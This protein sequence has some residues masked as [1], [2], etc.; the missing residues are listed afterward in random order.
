MSHAVPESAPRTETVAKPRG[1]VLVIFAFLL[2]ILLGMAAFVV[3]LAW[4]WSNQLQVQRAADAGALAGVIH[5][6]GNPNGGIAA[7]RAES[8]KNGFEHNVNGV[9][10]TANPDPAFPR[11]MIVNVSAPVDTFFMALFGFSE[12]TVDRTAKAEYVLPVPMG[13]PEN[14]YGVF[15]LTRG[16]TSTQDVTVTNPQDNPGWSCGSGNTWN[17]GN[18]CAARFPTTSTSV[19]PAGTWTVNPTGSGDTLANSLGSNNNVY[20]RASHTSSQ[21]ATSIWGGFGAQSGMP[22]PGA[23]ESLVIT[24]LQVRL[25]DA[26]INSTC[27]GS[28]FRRRALLEQRVDLVNR[29]EHADQ[30]SPHDDK[31][32]RLRCRQ[33]DLD[34]R[35]GRPYLGAERL[36]RCELP[37]ANRF[38]RLQ[39][40][41]NLQ[42]GHGRRA[43]QLELH[44]PGHH[45]HDRHDEPGG[46]KPQ[47]PGTACTSGKAQCREADGVALNPRG[48]WGMV[49][50]QGAENVNGDAY[51]TGYDQRSTSAVAPACSSVTTSNRACYDAAELLQ[52]RDRD[53]TRQHRRVCLRLRP[54]LLRCRY[55]PRDRRALVQR[56]DGREHVLHP[57]QHP[58]HSFGNR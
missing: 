23:G 39:R 31:Q 51:Q 5:L 14:Y 1:Q 58:G 43:S 41:P 57:V 26:F 44:H 35:L 3:D 29:G 53:A 13:S 15:G 20:A 33:R 17:A 10:V 19:S 16:L 36:Q 49:N 50:T 45:N 38:G 18:G 12:V 34:K 21:A 22:T 8:Q 54:W 40:Q 4:I 11:R 9:V 48:F 56:V 52:L 28:H 24:G 37:H 7:A 32:H 55:R 2:T 27:S 30:R 46:R 47:G 42:R 25:S 6:P